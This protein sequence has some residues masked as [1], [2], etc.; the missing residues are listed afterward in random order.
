MFHNCL[1]NATHSVISEGEHE[2]SSALSVG[3]LCHGDMTGP[4]YKLD[5]L[6]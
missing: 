2:G 6:C 5:T 4:Q 1:V 3:I